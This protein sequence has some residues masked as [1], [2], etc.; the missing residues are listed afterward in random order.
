MKSSLFLLSLFITVDVIA[1]DYS[2]SI[3]QADSIVQ[4]FVE[5]TSLPGMSISVFHEDEMVWSKGYGYADVQ[6][7]IPVDPSLTKFRI[8]SVSKS[9]TAAGMGVLMQGGKLDPDELIQTYVPHF[10]E[11]EYPITVKQVAG[12]LAGIRHYR[13]NEFMSNTLYETV[14]KGLEIFKDDPLLFE[15][16]TRYQYSSYGWNLISAVIAGAS[17]EEFLPFMKEMVFDP[18]GMNN[19]VPEWSNRDIPNLTK[20]Y[21]LGTYGNMEADAV[22]NSYKW[23]GGG[24]VGTTEDLI[25]FGIGMMDYEF[26]NESVQEELMFPQETSDGR[27]TNYGMGWRFI[28]NNG[29][30]WVGH[31]GG[32]V[33]GSTMFLINKQD[34]FIIAY[35]INRSSVG[36]DNLH[37]KVAEA[38][39]E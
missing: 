21:V 2:Q 5:S 13:G 15:P 6:N 16:G 9:L 26:I 36:F 33:G 37:F 20:F 22:D 8:G 7:Q 12:H 19:T 11:K 4:A 32:S 25:R 1:Q 31:S 39:L 24:F 3:Q 17:G 23:A 18:N 38:F 28:E 10:P 14:D 27:S 29:R 30:F 34:R 35:A